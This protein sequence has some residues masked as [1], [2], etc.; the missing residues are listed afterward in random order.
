[1]KRK[2]KILALLLLP[3]LA[4]ALTACEGKSKVEQVSIQSGHFAQ[5]GLSGAKQEPLE[6][7]DAKQMIMADTDEL[8]RA[9]DSHIQLKD[10]EEPTKKRNERL[11]YD[12]VGWHNYNFYYMDNGEK[13]QNYLMSRGHLVGYQFCGLN[14]EERNLVPETSWLNAGNYKGMNDSNQDSMLYYENRLD[15]WL[16]NHPN[17]RL[18][19]QVTPLYKGNELLPRQVRLAYVGYDN[20]GEKIRIRFNSPREEEGNGEATVVY[21]DNVSPN[22]KLNYATG[23]AENILEQENETSES[24]KDSFSSKTVYVAQNGSS[25]VYWY[26]KNAM[27]KSTNFDKVKSMSESEALEKGKTHATGEK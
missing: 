27:P 9:V 21:L 18:D 17:F 10:S 7:K 19:Y 20:K 25:K 14:D 12:P 4:V 5:E 24:S 3:L 1:M 22:A 2:K 13:K 16:A 23:T 8:H 6:Y 15:S 26:D 11:T